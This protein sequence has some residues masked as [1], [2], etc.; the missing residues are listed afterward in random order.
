MPTQS[1][2]Q[3]ESQ[4]DA[5]TD[6]PSAPVVFEGLEEITITAQRYARRVQ[7]APVSVT[8]MTADYMIKQ[9]IETADDVI[10][11][12]PGATFVGFN[13][14]QPEYSIRGISSRTEGSSLESAI[15]TVIDD[16]PISK[17]IL[18]NPA[19]FDMQRVEVLRG[20]QGTSFGRNASAG[21][22]H[23]VSQRP[24]FD[25][26]GRLTVG[27]G[28]MNAM[29]PMAISMCRYRKRSPRASRIISIHSMAIPN[30][31]PPAKDWMDRKISPFAVLC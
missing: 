11:N 31:F 2:A 24:T 4:A 8:A 13:K 14:T 29:K 17:D 1:F 3:T 25:L 21:L 6:S 7:D 5:Q 9:R 27:A 30:R 26:S 10:Q 28:S 19:M 23:L 22:V 20:P 12:T 16:V 15:L 18:K